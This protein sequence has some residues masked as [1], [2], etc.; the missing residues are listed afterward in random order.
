MEP[1][2]TEPHVT[3]MPCRLGVPV[4][5]R[6]LERGGPLTAFGGFSSGL[7]CRV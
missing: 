5:L 6:E 3:E 1:Q 2:N 7:G 4:L